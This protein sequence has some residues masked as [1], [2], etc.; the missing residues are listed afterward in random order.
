LDRIF[1]V[2]D[3][4]MVTH[5]PICLNSIHFKRG[6]KG[7]WIRGLSCCHL[8]SVVK[9]NEQYTGKFSYERGAFGG[10]KEAVK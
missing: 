8:R 6:D 9:E 2:Y 3:N 5:C 7:Q 1:K 10:I 4:T